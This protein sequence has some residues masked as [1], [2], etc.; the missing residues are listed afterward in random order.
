MRYLYHWL[1]KQSTKV[2]LQNSCPEK[3][4]K[5]H[6]KSHVPESLRD[7][8][9]GAFLRTFQNR[10]YAEQLRVISSVIDRLQEQGFFKIIINTLDWKYDSKGGFK[11]ILNIGLCGLKCWL[12]MFVL[13]CFL[14]VV[15]YKYFYTFFPTPNL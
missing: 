7:F 13:I 3:F 2:A 15:F 4:R 14:F 10:F 8:Y 1:P 6:Q 5:I 12:Y 11:N 9:A